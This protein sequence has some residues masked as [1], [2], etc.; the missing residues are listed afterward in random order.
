MI[1][2]KKRGHGAHL[3]I[4]RR[5]KKGR[6]A[7]VA[8][9]ADREISRFRM[10]KFLMAVRRHRSARVEIGVDHRAERTRT[11]EPRVEVEAQLARHGKIGTLACRDDN[12]IGRGKSER[13]RRS[14][15]CDD[16]AI[17]LLLDAFRAETENEFQPS[18]VDELLHIAAE[19]AARGNLIGRS[20]SEYARNSFAAH[21][22]SIISMI[23]E[24]SF[25]AL[26]A[27]PSGLTAATLRLGIGVNQ[28]TELRVAVT[29]IVDEKSDERAHS[30]HISTIDN[31]PA[32]ARASHQSGARENADMSSKRVLGGTPRSRRSRRPEPRSDVG[33]S[34]VGKSQAASAG[35]A[36]PAPTRHEDL[37]S[38]RPR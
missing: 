10:C 21:S 26:A 22:P 32:V 12:A 13:T 35:R 28:R 16:E 18:A 24:I 11:F 3:L 6:C 23:T 33:A 7:S 2:G 4:T 38:R 8:L 25:T 31:R 20:T 29:A 27:L 5:H 19:L 1:A 30:I 14:A 37:T 9:D 15:P 36:Q 34:A 17:T